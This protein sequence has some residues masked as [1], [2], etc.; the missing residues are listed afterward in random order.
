LTTLPA[1]AVRIAS[2]AAIALSLAGCVLGLS[3][4]PGDFCLIANPITFADADTEETR[5][6]IVRHNAK[7]VCVCDGECE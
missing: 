3:A 5:D 2:L 1:L 6:Q 4:P 7:W